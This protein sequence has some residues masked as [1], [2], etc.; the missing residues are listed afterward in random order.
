M[1][2]PEAP[3][4]AQTHP[5]ETPGTPAL[6]I[7]FPEPEVPKGQN[8]FEGPSSLA[9]STAMKQA[10]VAPESLTQST[11]D[12]GQGQGSSEP[13]SGG[14]VAAAPN[15][16]DVRVGVNQGAAVAVE[17]PLDP[18]RES[19]MPSVP[20]APPAIDASQLPPF[21]LAMSEPGPA[22]PA[23][24]IEPLP[25][26]EAPSSAPKAPAQGD[27]MG[28]VYAENDPPAPGTLKNV[29]WEN[30][31]EVQATKKQ[32]WWMLPACFLAGV[33]VAGVLFLKRKR[34]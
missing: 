6:S 1:P 15:G 10:V 28:F 13:A 27:K 20:L 33:L 12:P 25:P 34:S 26:P 18:P 2:L 30:T 21:E 32:E 22:S 14:S 23:A 11:E 3:V 8:P 16:N 5:Q 9:H 24:E 29:D 4:V 7:E 17:G 31:D 19:P